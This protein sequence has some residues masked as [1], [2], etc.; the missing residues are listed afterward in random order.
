MINR[1]VKSVKQDPVDFISLG[2]VLVA[3]LIAFVS[4]SH[5]P[6]VQKQIIALTGLSY[7][8]WGIFHHWHREDFNLKIG[9]EYLLVAVFGVVMAMFVVLRG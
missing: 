5:E 8:F 4:F 3:S 2:V 6:L 7:L 1:L 9:L